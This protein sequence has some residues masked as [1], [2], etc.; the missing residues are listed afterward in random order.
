MAKAALK[1]WRALDERELM[2]YQW[3]NNG[4]GCA[5]CGR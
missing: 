2:V 3:I 1:G 5:S 4:G